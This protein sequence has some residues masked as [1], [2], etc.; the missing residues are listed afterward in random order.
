MQRVQQGKDERR[1]VDGISGDNKIVC[2]VIRQGGTCPVKGTN[3]D[4][5]R[6]IIRRDVAPQDGSD[7]NRKIGSN[8]RPVLRSEGK[9]T[10]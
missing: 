8:D 2:I 6:G 1:R 9:A 3:G 5:V 4:P 10:R 7:D